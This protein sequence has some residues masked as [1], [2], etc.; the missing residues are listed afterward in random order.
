MHDQHPVG[1]RHQRPHHVLDADDRDAGLA[2]P[3]K[4]RDGGVDLGRVEAAERLVE[5]QHER[6]G[7]ERGSDHQP[8]AVV[9]GQPRCDRGRPVLQPDQL[10][11]RHPAGDVTGTR[12]QAAGR[13]PAPEAGG[14]IRVLQRGQ[15]LCRRRL[16][17]RAGQ[18]QPAAVVDLGAADRPA[19]ELD[20]AGAGDRVP[21]DRVE[22][23]RLAGPVRAGDP[24]HLSRGH[25]ERQAVDRAQPAVQL[26]D[27]AHLEHGRRGWVFGLDHCSQDGTWNLP[28]V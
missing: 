18:P 9:D 24:E 11:R 7:G 1:E 14:Q 4:Q 15:R 22:Q 5:Q 8:L 21:G 20:L 23:R 19:L 17:E 12:S 28:V 13:P 27:V 26:G 6:L 16:L 10:K 2:D 3:A 25:R